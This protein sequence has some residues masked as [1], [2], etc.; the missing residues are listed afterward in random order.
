MIKLQESFIDFSWKKSFTEV[1]GKFDSQV[2]EKFNPKDYET[3]ITKYLTEGRK[4]YSHEYT[5]FV[6]L[7]SKEI[8]G[9]LEFS[10]DYIEILLNDFFSKYDLGKSVIMDSFYSAKKDERT[11]RLMYLLTKS[12]VESKQ[13][14]VFP[15]LSVGACLHSLKR[16]EK[17]SKYK[18][19]D[20]FDI[21][22]AKVA[23]PYCDFYRKEFNWFN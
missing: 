20:S 5:Y 22:H 8:Y 16:W 2:R 19:S 18:R 15:A 4:D 23:L 11:I 12:I 1:F 13:Y 6:D 9:S 10:Q 7:L 14:G 17:N 3:R 21:M